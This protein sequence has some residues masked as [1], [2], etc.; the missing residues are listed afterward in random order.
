MV[1]VFYICEVGGLLLAGSYGSVSVDKLF[2]GSD[3]LVWLVKGDV[4]EEGLVRA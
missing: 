3:R 1:D 4:K 2:G